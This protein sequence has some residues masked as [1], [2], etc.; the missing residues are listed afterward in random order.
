MNN[1][2]AKTGR[3]G[4]TTVNYLCLIIMNACFHYVYQNRD[5]SHLV[6]V[7][8]LLA[9][10][11]VIATFVRLHWKSGLWK[12]THA[13]ASRLD[14]RELQI[15]HSSVGRAY[16]WFTVICLS[17]MMAHA[18]LFRLVPGLD[19]VITM[20]LVASLIYLAHTLPGSILAWTENEVP[21]EVS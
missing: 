1:P 18:V 15:T 10:V 12:L 8:G 7:A 2:Q 17:L 5:S 13:D 11:T 16:A 3:R 4:L 20:P 14:E 19:F 9:L 6:D 21:G